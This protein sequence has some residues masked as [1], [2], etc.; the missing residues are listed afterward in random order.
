MKRLHP[1]ELWVFAWFDSRLPDFQTQR[2]LPGWIG[3][4]LLVVSATVFA[5]AWRPGLQAQSQE[6]EIQSELR[7]QREASALVASRKP[8]AAPKAAP[9]P[10]VALASPQAQQEGIRLVRWLQV[11][12]S[13]R[14]AQL[15]RGVRPSVQLNTLRLD[16]TAASID[17]RGQVPQL[18][19]LDKLYTGWI[20]AGIPS[21]QIGRHEA[22]E[23]D[24]SVVHEFQATLSWERAR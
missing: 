22:I 10:T 14:L 24:G 11:D 18:A 16:T 5:L 23:R 7:A 13:Q 12:W 17:V 3:I 15:E 21:V 20:E 6:R 19:E 8:V 4:G 2:T 9:R 1:R